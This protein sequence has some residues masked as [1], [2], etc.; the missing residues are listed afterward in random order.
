MLGNKSNL[1]EKLHVDFLRN[2]L[3]VRNSTASCAILGE[4]GRYPLQL[5]WHKLAC[6][7][8]N[9]MF[10][11][12]SHRLAKSAFLDNMQLA[13]TNRCWFTRT[14]DMLNGHLEG[15]SV[16][17]FDKVN[18]PEFLDCTKQQ[19]FRTLQK[20]VGTKIQWY[21]QHAL[22]GRDTAE[23]YSMCPYLRLTNIHMRSL[24]AR[25]RCGSHHLANETGRWSRSKLLSQDSPQRLCQICTEHSIEDETHFAL[26]RPAYH[27]IRVQFADLLQFH[28][29]A[30][31]I[32]H[33]DFASLSVYL[34]RCFALRSTSL[35]LYNT[36]SVPWTC[37]GSFVDGKTVIIII[38][39]W[40]LPAFAWPCS[41]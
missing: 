18:L 33:A 39:C 36:N 19:Y 12:D 40:G 2:I 27:E 9:R 28:N 11:L 31:L 24:L 41:C 29:I 3:H 16:V 21:L 30:C 13:N 5:H 26:T 22:Q 38:I 34:E 1:L 23:S 8:W 15:S 4:F 20:S 6:K 14:R 25:F 10:S 17:H 37:P 32:N 7:Y 35:S